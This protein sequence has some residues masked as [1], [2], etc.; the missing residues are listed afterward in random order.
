MTTVAGSCG[1][2]LS[3]L[4]ATCT[5]GCAVAWANQFIQELGYAQRTIEIGVDNKCSMRL[6][7]QG[8]GSL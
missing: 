8:T 5:I 1:S 2:A 4:I 6:L 7:E 3:E